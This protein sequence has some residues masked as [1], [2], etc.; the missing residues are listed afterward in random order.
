MSLED[1]LGERAAGAAVWFFGGLV[2]WGLLRAAVQLLGFEY[3]TLVGV[4]L[5]LY[6]GFAFGREMRN[7]DADARR[8][9]EAGRRDGE[10]NLPL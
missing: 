5:A 2:C 3:G 7:R 10:F 6:L 8:S 4:L 9:R 1:R